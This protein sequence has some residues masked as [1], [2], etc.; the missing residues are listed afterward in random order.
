[1]RTMCERCSSGPEGVEGHEQLQARILGDGWMAFTC[2]QCE[3]LW[4]RGIE[5]DFYTWTRLPKKLRLA[6]VH[7]PRRRDAAL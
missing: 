7:I 6:G 4:S 2:E 1:M 5:P 3:A